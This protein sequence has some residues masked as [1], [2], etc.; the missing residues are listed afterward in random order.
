MAQVCDVVVELRAGEGNVDAGEAED[1]E[2]QEIAE[3][4]E[5]PG[6]RRPDDRVRE[7]DAK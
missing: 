7:F 5:A 2:G 3:L 6:R 1:F 4:D